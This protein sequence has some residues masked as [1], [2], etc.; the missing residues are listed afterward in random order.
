MDKEINKGHGPYVFCMHGQNYHHIGSLI[1]EEGNK[2]RW[3][4]LYIYDT[5]HEV[6]NRISVVIN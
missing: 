2:P 1:P 3:A 6:E 5:E 4:Q